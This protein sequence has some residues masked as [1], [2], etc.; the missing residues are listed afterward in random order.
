M[1]F[2]SKVRQA[3]KIDPRI[4]FDNSIMPK[5]DD[6]GQI[7]RHQV[8]EEIDAKLGRRYPPVTLPVR[9]KQLKQTFMNLGDPEPWED[10]DTLD[11]EHDDMPSLA[12]GELERH[13]ELR[14]YARLA[15][16]EMPLLASMSQTSMRG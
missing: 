2:R 5:K 14:H 3:I 15:T 16:W 11:D 12:H 9:R 8:K 10:E 7:E 4:A 1:L 13:R 6:M